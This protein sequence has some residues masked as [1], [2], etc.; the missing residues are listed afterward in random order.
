MAVYMISD[1]HLGH[2]SI[3]K[4]RPDLNLST[5]DEHDDFIVDNILSTVSK[6][7]KL[8]LLGDVCFS[9]E[10]VPKLKLITDYVESCA[11]IL[12]NHDLESNARPS[13]HTLYELFGK[14]IFGIQS[15]KSCW[16]THGPLHEDELR[17]KFNIH[18]HV[19]SHSLSDP[20][21]YNVSCEAV[22]YKPMEFTKILEY[23]KDVNK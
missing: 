9:H 22:N 1:L 4:Y 2:R 18:G 5:V 12:G 23:L 8:Y 11:L 21:Y 17:G 3:L 19:H 6:R 14:N 7:D 13:I 15:Y 20:K 10:T 16:L